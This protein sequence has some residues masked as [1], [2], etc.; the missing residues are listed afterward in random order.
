MIRL[1]I[2][3]K[4][5]SEFRADNIISYSNRIGGAQRLGIKTKHVSLGYDTPANYNTYNN[6]FLGAGE[7]TWHDRLQTL[8]NSLVDTVYWFAG[9]P[10]T[11]YPD[12]ETEDADGN[13]IVN[14]EAIKR[15]LAKKPMRI[16]FDKE[17]DTNV[18][19]LSDLLDKIA[20]EP[21]KIMTRT[22]NLF[23]PIYS[24]KSLIKESD[25][26]IFSGW[27]SAINTHETCTKMFKPNKIY[28][29]SFDIEFV[30]VPPYDYATQAL[31]F[32]FYDTNSKAVLESFTSYVQ[33]SQIVV[34]NKI[35]ILLTRTM[36]ADLK[37]A[38][39]LVYSGYCRNA[40]ENNKWYYVTSR[41]S[42]IMLTEGSQEVDYVPYMS[43]VKTIA[44]GVKD[45]CK[46]ILNGSEPWVQYTSGPDWIGTLTSANLSTHEN[47]CVQYNNYWGFQNYGD[48][49][50]FLWL[51]NVVF[52]A[53]HLGSPP[54]PSWETTNSDGKAIANIPKI[55]ADLAKKPLIV[56]YDN[57]AS[58]PKTLAELLKIVRREVYN[59]TSEEVDGDTLEVSGKMSDGVLELDSDKVSVSGSTLQL[60][61][62]NSSSSVIVEDGTLIVSGE[63]DNNT[64]ALAG[65]VDNN[66]LIL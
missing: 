50:K 15:D 10:P 24:H 49:N 4:Y 36:P 19:T 53:W 5:V 14:M 8:V 64:L 37:N 16:Y 56:Y 59:N 9:L 22:R 31:G 12:W 35:H 41:F 18:K 51:L 21:Q 13:K 11:N 57:T 48:A 45:E 26:F 65:S 34:G 60:G 28:T 2:N 54:Y 39:L 38:V 17:R 42:N 43:E 66:E 32:N 47:R 40:D 29:L 1:G 46:L 33:S 44:W 3:P 62:G 7:Y 52:L 27:G 25:G 61:G 20:L 58:K 30:E 63:V 23:V 55:K 6:A